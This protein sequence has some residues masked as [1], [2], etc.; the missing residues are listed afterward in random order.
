[1]EYFRAAPGK[2]CFLDYETFESLMVAKDSCSLPLTKKQTTMM[3]S[4]PIFLENLRL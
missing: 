2:P 3:A 1:M 4:K